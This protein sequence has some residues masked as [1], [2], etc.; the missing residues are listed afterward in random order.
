MH[1]CV[2]C[3]SPLYTLF[4]PYHQAM[5]R[6]ANTT[7]SVLLKAP[8]EGNQAHAHSRRPTHSNEDASSSPCVKK[9]LQVKPDFQIPNTIT[10]YTLLLGSSQHKKQFLPFDPQEKSR[11]SQKAVYVCVCAGKP[12]NKAAICMYSVLSASSGAFPCGL[13]A[14]PP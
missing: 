7:S 5:Q 9:N 8:R 2:R 11:P 1:C 14:L 13:I 3:S 10:V 4:P 12:D 6:S